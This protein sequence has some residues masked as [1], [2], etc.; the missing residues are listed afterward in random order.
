VATKKPSTIRNDRSRIECH[1][2][3]LL[4]N[5]K[6]REVTR[7]DVERFQRDVAGAGLR[8]TERQGTA[9]VAS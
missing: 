2:K 6:I 7:A 5:R 1:I 9:G 8:A 4:G 3:P